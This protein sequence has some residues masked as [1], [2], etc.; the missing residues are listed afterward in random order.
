MRLYVRR[1]WNSGQIAPEH[2]QA[3]VDPVIIRRFDIDIGVVRPSGRRTCCDAVGSKPLG[4]LTTKETRTAED[5][6]AA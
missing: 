3:A 6:H 2:D 4:K 1:D 5:G